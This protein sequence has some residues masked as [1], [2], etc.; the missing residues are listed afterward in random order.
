MPDEM[1]RHGQMKV[2]ECMQDRMPRNTRGKTL[3]EHVRPNGSKWQKESTVNAEKNPGNVFVEQ[4]CRHCV[5]VPG[6]Q[7]LDAAKNVKTTYARRT[8]QNRCKMSLGEQRSDEN[9]ARGGNG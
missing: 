8:C 6:G 5:Q 4:F 2:S 9:V 3:R 7:P 1:V